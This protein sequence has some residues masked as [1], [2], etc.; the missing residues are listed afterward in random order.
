MIAGKKDLEIK[1][2]I[3][4]MNLGIQTICG[5]YSNNNK[6]IIGVDRN[7]RKLFNI[8]FNGDLTV[9]GVFIK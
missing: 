9:N 1:K 7:N 4:T 3:N 8:L 2:I 5:L 6:E